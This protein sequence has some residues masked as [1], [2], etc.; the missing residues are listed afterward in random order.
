MLGGYLCSGQDTS[1]PTK[2]AGIPGKHESDVSLF[3][4]SIETHRKEVITLHAKMKGSRWDRKG[5]Y[6][7]PAAALAAMG[8]KQVGTSPVVDSTTPVSAVLDI[9]T[10][11]GNV[12]IESRNQLWHEKDRAYVPIHIVY[13][14]D[15]KQF[16]MQEPAMEA[17]ADAGTASVVFKRNVTYPMLFPQSVWPVFFQLGRFDTVSDIP[18]KA[19]ESIYIPLNRMNIQLN[20]KSDDGSLAVF[21]I[22]GVTSDG[23]DALVTCEPLHAYRVTAVNYYTKTQSQLMRVNLN[24]NEMHHSWLPSSWTVDLYPVDG[25]GQGATHRL[26]TTLEEIRINNNIEP[27]VFRPDLRKGIVI[28]KEEDRKKY[29]VID[30]EHFEEIP[31][32]IANNR[33]KTSLLHWLIMLTGGILLVVIS[34]RLRKKFSKVSNAQ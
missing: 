4:S 2:I 16:A 19:G 21:R 9:N 8:M 15:G 24:Y 22:T 11:S 17:H 5:A 7:L 1:V 10:K 33:R 18:A 14:F 32:D 13:F 23:F 25:K 20:S 6:D 34:I 30:K 28:E 26:A 31:S 3:L 27:D 29:R 12:R